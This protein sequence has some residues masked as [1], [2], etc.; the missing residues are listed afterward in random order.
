MRY[1]ER[2]GRATALLRSSMVCMFAANFM[3][4]L[5]SFSQAYIVCGSVRQGKCPQMVPAP[6]NGPL[7]LVSLSD[8]VDLRG[9]MTTL[10]TITANSHV[11]MPF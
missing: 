8:H 5:K 11:R 7:L 6:S 4:P 1:T 9:A 2:G 3:Q 10:C